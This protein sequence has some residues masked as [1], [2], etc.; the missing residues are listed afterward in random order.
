MRGDGTARDACLAVIFAALLALA[1]CV[2]GLPMKSSGATPS[3]DFPADSFREVADEKG[4][5]YTATF[6]GIEN[7]GV[8]VSDYDRDGWPDLLALGGT[9]P[10][11]FHN[12]GGEFERSKGLPDDLQ[13]VFKAALW[14]DYD[15][16]GW[17]DL[18]LLR[19]YDTPVFL[20][21]NA[22]TFRRS[23]VGFET[24]MAVPKS[25][26]AAD[27]NSDGCPDVFVAQ[28]ADWDN[29]VPTAGKPENQGMTVNTSEDNGN[30]NYLY[31]GTCEEF[32]NV[33]DAG[34]T[35]E[36][37]SLATSFVD[38]TGD[39]APDIYVAND[40]NN[41]TLYVN[42]GNGTFDKQVLPG[43]TDRNAMSSEI[44][45]FNGDGRPDVFVTNVFIPQK[46]RVNLGPVVGRIEG[47]NMLL[48]RGNSTFRDVAT[49]W[50][51]MKGGWGWAATA[52]DLNNDGQRD[53]LH[54]A[55][56]HKMPPKARGD[57]LGELDDRPSYLDY[58]VLFNRIASDNFTSVNASRV[59]FEESSG[60]GVG[61]LDYDRD[62]DQ[63]IVI[64]VVQGEFKLYENT[65]GGRSLQIDVEDGS[66]TLALGA[67][68]AVTVDGETRIYYNNAK[69]DFL[70]QDNRVHHVGLGDAEVEKLQVVWPD[71][72][73]QVWTNVSANH[74]VTVYPNGTKRSVVTDGG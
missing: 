34:I 46:F 60:R 48:N 73:E 43:N 22:G 24:E 71:G 42:H 28:N 55:T 64:G 50:G 57:K 59:G 63:D 20:E 52:V 8:Y 18:L 49:Q 27:Y 37:W 41:D 74:R 62:G 10:A 58:P 29:T 33:E 54:T 26:S 5:N 53:L 61:A 69:S 7:G 31:R 4:L 21:N 15:Q 19:E 6:R 2:G 35:G 14:V 11:L 70:S 9:D 67:R 30:P 1:G 25:V 66:D 36:Y 65:L 68:V 32:Q 72:T 12:T 47:N 51:V 3:S 44:A 17:E 45:D 56:I 13:G 23:Q 40:F 38:M 16:D 39:G